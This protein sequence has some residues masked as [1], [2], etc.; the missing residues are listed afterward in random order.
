MKNRKL[1]II[2]LLKTSYPSLYGLLL[3]RRPDLIKSALSNY[4]PGNPVFP[5]NMLGDNTAVSPTIDNPQAPPQAV[6]TTWYQDIFSV[7]K[8]AIPAYQ[9]QQLFKLQL[10]RAERG[11]AP[12]DPALVAPRINVSLPVAQQRQ[13]QFALFGFLGLG[14]LGIYF[15][16]RKNKKR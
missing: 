8:D 4:S 14:A 9:Q 2:N 13:A 1:E 6:T 11:L 16:A 3:T 7:I 5:S 10:K 12:I 15:L